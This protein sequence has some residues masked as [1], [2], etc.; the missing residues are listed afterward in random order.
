MAHDRDLADRVR[1]ELDALLEPGGLAGPDGAEVRERRMFGGLA[2]LVDG[3]MALAV[4]DGLL[5]RVDPDEQAALLAE[6]HVD[7]FVMPERRMRGW[8]RVLPEGCATDADVR[9]WVERGVTRVGQLR[10]DGG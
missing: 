3:Q 7:E 6:P 4:G 1:R 9:R 8:L 10:R 5:V 2:F